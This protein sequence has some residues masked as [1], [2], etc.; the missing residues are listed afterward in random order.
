MTSARVALFKARTVFCCYTGIVL[1]KHTVLVLNSVLVGMYARRSWHCMGPLFRLLVIWL[2]LIPGTP[3]GTV[4]NARLPL[5]GRASCVQ[6]PPA[7]PITPSVEEFLFTTPSLVQFFGTIL[8]VKK[9]PS[10]GT[11]IVR[12]DDFRVRFNSTCCSAKNLKLRT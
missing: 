3:Q 9:I 2:T 12:D 4:S 10:C 11:F 6:C 1:Q 7:T 5:I 8:G